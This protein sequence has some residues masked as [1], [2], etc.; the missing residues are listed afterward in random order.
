MNT[1]ELY[2]SISQV[3]EVPIITITGTMHC[4]HGP[5]MSAMLSGMT[6]L[7]KNSFVFDIT[8]LIYPEEKAALCMVEILGGLPESLKLHLVCSGFLKHLI[9]RAQIEK[10]ISLYSTTDEIAELL[11]REWMSQQS[12]TT[13]V[14]H[15]T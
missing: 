3:M 7:C 10:S 15:Q 11:R 8:K 9:A 13:P 6:E 4:A 14:R 2:I 5:A 1:P 12:D